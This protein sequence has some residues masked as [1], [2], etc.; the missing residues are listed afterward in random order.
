MAR[1]PVLFEIELKAPVSFCFAWLTDYQPTDKDINPALTARKVVERTREYVKMV[2]E[3]MGPPFNKR[4]STIWLHA[5]DAWDAEAKG[6]I[7]DYDLHYRLTAEAKGTRLVISGVT[8]TKPSCPF[9]TR[10]E[11]H[12]RFVKAWPLYKAALEKD[13]AADVP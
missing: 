4:T 11:N 8:S 2:D 13:F 3:S 5:P 1:L 10:E 12:Q 9:K 6:T 7:Y